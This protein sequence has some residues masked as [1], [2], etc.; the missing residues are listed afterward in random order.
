MPVFLAMGYLGSFGGLARTCIIDLYAGVSTTPVEMLVD[1]IQTDFPRLQ[2]PPVGVEVLPSALVT[3]M[4]DDSRRRGCAGNRYSPGDS[5]MK[6]LGFPRA[7][8]TP[9]EICVAELYFPQ[10][11]FPLGEIC[12]EGLDY[13]RLASL[14]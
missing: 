5:F 11:R 8:C 7:S 10:A 9:V 3:L 4:S 14:T 13:I 6:Y 12:T 2:F 1:D